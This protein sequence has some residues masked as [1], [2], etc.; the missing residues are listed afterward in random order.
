MAYKIHYAEIDGSDGGY[1]FD[2][3]FQTVD[4]ARQAWRDY[5]YKDDHET[6][7]VAIYEEDCDT[8]GEEVEVLN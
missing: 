6:E 2:K 7:V 1:L 3:T 8:Y 4:A 5:P